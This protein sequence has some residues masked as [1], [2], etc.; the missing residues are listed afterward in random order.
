MKLFKMLFALFALMICLGS[1]NLSFAEDDVADEEEG[2]EEEII[3][4]D[5]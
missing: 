5:E 2:G 3:I 1:A 4:G